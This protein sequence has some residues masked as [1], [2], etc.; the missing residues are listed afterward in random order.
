MLKRLGFFS[1]ALV[2]ATK[3]DDSFAI[4]SIT[5]PASEAKIVGTNNILHLEF[6]DLDENDADE[7]TIRE[8]IAFNN[9]HAEQI[10]EF[11]EKIQENPKINTLVVHC[12]VGVSRSAAVSLGVYHYLKEHNLLANDFEFQDHEQTYYANTLVVSTLQKFINE[13]IYI[14]S[15][16]DARNASEGVIVHIPKMFKSL[17]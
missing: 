7:E 13:T 8:G 14:P 5:N 9:N 17:K 2:E 1:Q 11:I 10:I 4:I 12:Y 15:I 16:E 6:L 3:F